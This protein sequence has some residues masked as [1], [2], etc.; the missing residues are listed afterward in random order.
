MPDVREVPG[1]DQAQRLAV[2]L[3]SCAVHARGSNGSPHVAMQ[4]GKRISYG[5][6][7]CQ[8]EGLR[9]LS[10]RTTILALGGTRPMATMAAQGWQ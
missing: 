2:A 7:S 3:I 9:A 8:Q 10:D 1:L 6:L 4:S 5:P